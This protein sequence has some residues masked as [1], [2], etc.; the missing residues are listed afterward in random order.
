MRLH[1]WNMKRYGQPKLWPTTR[2]VRVLGNTTSHETVD[3]SQFVGQFL[4]HMFLIFS[5]SV[6]D[7]HGQSL[8]INAIPVLRVQSNDQLHYNLPRLHELNIPYYM[9]SI[10]A[11]DFI[12]LPSEGVDWFFLEGTSKKYDQ[13]RF[14]LGNAF[15]SGVPT[16]VEKFD[17]NRVVLPREFNVR[18][19]PE[20][21]EQSVENSWKILAN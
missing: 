18:Q 3:V 10:N 16:Y 20:S 5:Y 1:Y 15:A 4:D 21:L 12:K 19:F 11:I 14:V 6:E 13:M 7:F 8:P 9:V 17:G 2:I